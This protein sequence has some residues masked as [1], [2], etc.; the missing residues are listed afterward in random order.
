[1]ARSSV[2]TAKRKSTPADF[3][4]EV[5]R[6]SGRVMEEHSS[7]ANAKRKLSAATDREEYGSSSKKR[8][9]DTDE[10]ER[11]TRNAAKPVSSEYLK[12]SSHPK[13]SAKTPPRSRKPQSSPSP[14]TQKDR[15]SRSAAHYETA[16]FS[17]DGQHQ[18]RDRLH[19]STKRP[20]PMYRPDDIVWME[21]VITLPS[22]PKSVT[23]KQRGF[24][25]IKVNLSEYVGQPIYWPCVIRRVQLRP[26]FENVVISGMELE[27]D[28]ANSFSVFAPVHPVVNVSMHPPVYTVEP[29]MIN[30]KALRVPE[31]R[32]YPLASVPVVLKHIIENESLLRSNGGLHEVD[33]LLL[34]YAQALSIAYK[35]STSTFNCLGK[36]AIT[37]YYIGNVELND[38]SYDGLQ[39]G[40]EIIYPCDVIR[41]SN[42]GLKPEEI[43]DYPAEFL[44]LLGMNET[45]FHVVFIQDGN[46]GGGGSSN[47]VDIQGIICYPQDLEKADDF[48]DPV[49]ARQMCL[50]HDRPQILCGLPVPRYVN[51][52][53]RTMHQ[54]PIIKIR[55]EHVLGKFY[56][57]RPSMVSDCRMGKVKAKEE[58][59]DPG[60]EISDPIDLAN[61]T[62]RRMDQI[63]FSS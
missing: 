31:N 2:S 33:G 29:L 59:S 9:S 42:D 25:D 43:P 32:L 52:S 10:K 44:H 58:L 62:Y 56:G 1:M 18:N 38:W 3:E 49:I 34:N 48:C 35:H 45:L 4:D 17:R 47:N 30:D 54:V 40:G 22:F 14:I 27:A 23:I 57:H 28:D 60:K 61:A 13:A 7:S 63:P 15:F 26:P 16:P 46:A 12:N 37:R 21:A 55:V 20:I 5:F 39:L 41:V 8:R 19:M 6:P 50:W 53:G 24:R 36:H 51:K 11:D